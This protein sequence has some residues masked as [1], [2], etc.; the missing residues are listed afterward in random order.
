[1]CCARFDIENIVLKIEKPSNKGQFS[2]SSQIDP[3]QLDARL[4]LSLRH[5]L[6]ILAQYIFYVQFI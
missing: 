5:Y 1:M 3:S 4:N 6:F 2:V